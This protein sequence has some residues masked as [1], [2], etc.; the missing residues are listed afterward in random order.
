MCNIKQGSSLPKL[1]MK[2]SLIIWDEAPMVRRQCFEAMDRTFRDIV[3]KA[4]PQLALCPFVGKCVVL[5]GDFRQ[6]LPIIPGGTRS[7]IVFASIKSSYLWSCCQILTLTKN[8]RVQV[9]TTNDDISELKEFSK[10]ML[11]VGDGKLSQPNDGEAEIEIP[12]YLLL[13]DF[14]DLLQAL[15]DTTYPNFEKKNSLIQ[16]I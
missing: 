5:G 7:D 14:I 13:Q 8:L 15:F 2:T 11:K 1:I 4:N 3:Q 10:W 9:G 16:I 12:S 6:I